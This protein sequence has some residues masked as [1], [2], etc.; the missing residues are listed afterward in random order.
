MGS[1]FLYSGECRCQ[2]EGKNIENIGVA[3]GI[4]YIN[5]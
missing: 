1:V 2:E 4:I 3:L 5:W